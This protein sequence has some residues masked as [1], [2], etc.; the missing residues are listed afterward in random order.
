MLG[1]LLS[2]LSAYIIAFNLQ[3]NDGEYIAIPLSRGNVHLE[4]FSKLPKIT[5][6]VS[7]R[8]QPQAVLSAPSIYTQPSTLL[9]PNR[10][11][12]VNQKFRGSK[13]F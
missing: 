3:N 8:I 11:E 4:K 1:S 5:Q 6:L 9:P 13:S 2:V 7:N 12:S 10:E